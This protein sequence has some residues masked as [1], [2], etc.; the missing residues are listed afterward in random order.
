[1]EYSAGSAAAALAAAGV[2]AAT[3]H[4]TTSGLLIR[5]PRGH[6]LVDAGWSHAV[7]EQTAELTDAGRPISTRI[8]NS[9]AWRKWTPEALALVGEA[10]AGLSYVL[11]THAHF[12]HM[13][14]AEDLPGVPVLLTPAEIDFLD[15]QLRVPA[16]VSP[17][18]IRAIS[19]RV[20]PMMLDGG[21]YLGFPRSH[22]LF[23]DGAII[24]VP[25]PGHT[26]G[27][28]GVFASAAGRRVFLVGDAALISEAVE[29]G[30]PKVD[31][32]RGAV[33]NDPAQS[34]RTIAALAAFHTAQ[35]D[36]VVIPAH[37]RTAWQGVFGETPGCA[38]ALAP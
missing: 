16:I 23:G 8:M 28:I 22:D 34:D 30:L 37:D 10:P 33:E 24:V 12:D 38:L 21:P 3:W 19:A 17:S 5:H 4:T 6:V 36:V 25:L 9:V 15:Q 2:T 27:S 32:L 18:N 26:P 20:E 14:G 1:M 29:R 13:A 7:A 31:P 11:P 35:P